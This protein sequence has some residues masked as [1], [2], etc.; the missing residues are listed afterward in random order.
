MITDLE[1]KQAMK[2]CGAVYP[3]PHDPEERFFRA[4]GTIWER[5]RTTRGSPGWHRE[6]P[7]PEPGAFEEFKRTFH[8][9]TGETIP[10]IK[11]DDAA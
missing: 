8:E 5:V 7:D 6:D 3:P 10:A 11:R 1:L 9:I 2:R 4:P